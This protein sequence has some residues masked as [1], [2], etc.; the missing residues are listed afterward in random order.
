MF[1]EGKCYKS[2]I[3]KTE[4]GVY[5]IENAKHGNKELYENR[6][7]NVGCITKRQ[8]I[9]PERYDQQYE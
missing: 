6:A 2:H 9:K 4:H 7:E 1:L 3:E 8:P 5:K